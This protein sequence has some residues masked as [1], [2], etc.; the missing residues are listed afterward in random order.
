L[1]AVLR[2]CSQVL[3]DILPAATLVVVAGLLRPEMKARMEVM[4]LVC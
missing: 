1:G 2:V 4:A 3:G